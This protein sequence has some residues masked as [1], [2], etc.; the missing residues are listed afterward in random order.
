MK[1]ILES[2]KDVNKFIESF[3]N[4]VF[5]ETEVV[6][7]PNDLISVIINYKEE[8][9]ELKTKYSILTTNFVKEWIEFNLE[10][11]EER[12]ST[13]KKTK[14]E[15]IKSTIDS[16]KE[17][18]AKLKAEDNIYNIDLTSPDYNFTYML[19]D[20]GVKPEA[21]VDKLEK[22]LAEID[23]PVNAVEESVEIET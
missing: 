20:Y 2:E 22:D 21:I 23:L 19:Y 6:I 18:L 5:N 12:E 17:E 3:E 10:V 16:V 8:I 1:I 14:A 9:S 4:G 13:D 7:N 15:V 11:N